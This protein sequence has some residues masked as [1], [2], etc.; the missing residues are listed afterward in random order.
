V[1]KRVLVLGGTGEARDLAARLADQT[2]TEVISS[3]AGR[4]SDPA[5]PPGQTRV[6]GFGGA[7]GLAAWLA[8][9]RIGAVVDATHPFAAA[10]TAAAVAATGRLKIPLLVLRRPGWTAGPGDDWRRVPSLAAAATRLSPGARVFL[11]VGSTEVSAFAPDQGRWFLIRSVQAPAPPLPPRAQLLLARGPFEVADELALMRRHAVDVLVT[12]DSGG[13][14]TS[15]KLTAARRLGLPVV[16]VDRPPAPDAPAV[17]TTAEA[18][19]WLEQCDGTREIE[20]WN[21]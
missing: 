8:A 13:E 18:I 12:R 11:T 19:T 14:M 9:E 5:R 16:M 1:T 3:L 20:P 6:G 15:A 4:T 10:M 7:A 21:R 2:G 17:A